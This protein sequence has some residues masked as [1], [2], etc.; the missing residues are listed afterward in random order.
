MIKKRSLSCAIGPYRCEVPAVMLVLSLIFVVL[1]ACLSVWQYQRGQQ[2]AAWLRS[3]EALSTRSVNDW[4]TQKTDIPAHF[5]K[6]NASGSFDPKHIFLLENRFYKERLGYDVLVPFKLSNSDQ[7]VIVNLGFVQRL[8]ERSMIP[9]LPE[10]PSTEM[11]LS[12]VALYPKRNRLIRDWIEN[13]A[14]S[15]PFV[16]QDINLEGM[17]HLLD[18]SFSPFL[19]DIDQP[20]VFNLPKESKSTYLSP[21]R[22]Y[23]Y[24]LQWGLLS[25][26]L[27]LCFIFAFIHPTR[28][29]IHD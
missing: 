22:H 14:V 20:N 25:L 23:G 28:E 16:I 2:K 4:A 12:G 11:T 15:W 26:T 27:T 29:K 24:A 18:M 7:W 21:Q 19:L 17:G 5:S 6:I 10:I 13:L 8:V 1:T 3:S 9:A